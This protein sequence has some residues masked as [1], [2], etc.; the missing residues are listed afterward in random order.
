M[1]SVDLFRSIRPFPHCFSIVSYLAVGFFTLTRLTGGIVIEF[2]CLHSI[3]IQLQKKT[4][5]RE[6]FV[7]VISSQN[8]LN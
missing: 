4:Q 8:E 2:I 6:D 1:I 5:N 3:R 7:L